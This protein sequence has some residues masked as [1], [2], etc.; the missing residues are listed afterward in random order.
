ME[1]DGQVHFL[2]ARPQRVEL[3]QVVV[4]MLVIGARPRSACRAAPSHES[5]APRRARS[6]PP[7]RRCRQRPRSPWARACRCRPR[8]SPRPNRSIPGNGL[9]ELGIGR[10]PNGQALVREQHFRIHAV[11]RQIGQTLLRRLAGAVAQGVFSRELD[12]ADAHRPEAFGL[13]VLAP[14]RINRDARQTFAKPLAHARAPKIRG[15]LHMAVRRDHEV[16]VGV[17]RPRCA[18]PVVDPWRLQP[19]RVVCVGRR[20]GGGSGHEVRLLLIRCKRH[21][22]SITPR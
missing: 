17:V 16:L 1:G 18:G 15:F 3:R 21:G 6:R 20:N 19:P 13:L 8:T 14:L 22:Y 4:W 2:N 5:R 10:R 9:A 11:R 7:R 12:V